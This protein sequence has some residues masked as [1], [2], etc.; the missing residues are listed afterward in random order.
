MEKEKNRVAML[1]VIAAFFLTTFKF[2]IGFLTGS[3]GILS[4]ALHSALDFVAAAITW[5][6]VRISDKPADDNHHYGHGKIENL[7][8]LIETLLLLITCIW[9]IYEASN[10]LISGKTQI[11]INAWSYIVIII[12]IVIDISRSRALKKVAKK[13]NSQALEADALHFSTDIWS[14]IV[15]LIGLICAN[16]NIFIADSIAALLV[17]FIVISVSYRL[18]KRSINVLLDS[19]PDDIYKTTKEL[20]TNFNGIESYSNLRI[21]ASGADIF[22]DVTIHV[23]ND[24]SIIEA[25][26]I[27]ENIEKK[28]NLTIERSSTTIHIEPN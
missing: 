2:T 24:L 25:H 18:G 10:R 19:V 17:A 21:R 8:A 11:E 7:S 26:N 13:Y 23:N 6:S 15:V 5:F 22:I 28:I 27:S 16:F 4:E 3:I 20:L 14:S 12:S 1:S 9:I